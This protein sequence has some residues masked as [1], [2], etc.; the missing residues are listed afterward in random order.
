MSLDPSKPRN[1]KEKS[2]KGEKGREEVDE[3]EGYGVEELRMA[4]RD[5]NRVSSGISAQLDLHGYKLFQRRTA[6][7]PLSMYGVQA[8]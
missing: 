4:R 3:S 5:K 1:E 2:R 8:R 7:S 6:E